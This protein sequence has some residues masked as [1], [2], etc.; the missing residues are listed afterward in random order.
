[1]R[2][3]AVAGRW[4]S[5]VV[6]PTIFT[7]SDRFRP[8]KGARRRRCRGEGELETGEVEI[9]GERVDLTYSGA[10]TPSPVMELESPAVKSDC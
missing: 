2:L 5:V 8:Q 7:G 6:E 4:S 3:L 10:L 1:M 9:A